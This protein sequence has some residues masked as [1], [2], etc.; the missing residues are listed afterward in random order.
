MSRKK[1]STVA[2]IASFIAVLLGIALFVYRAAFLKG[3][4][5]DFPDITVIPK[6]AEASLQAQAKRA[7]SFRPTDAEA[8]LITRLED[9]HLA[10]TGQETEVPSASVERQVDAFRQSLKSAA[11]TDHARVLL[12]G[13]YLADRFQKALEAFLAESP[14]AGKNQAG[15]MMRLIMTGGAFYMKAVQRKLIN[16]DHT[17]NVSKALPAVLFRYRWRILAG[18]PGD[19]GFTDTEQKLLFDFTIRYVD[20]QEVD[21]RLSAVKRLSALVPGYDS[22]IAEALVLYE[23]DRYKEAIRVLDGAVAR[24]RQDATV[25]NF[26]RAIERAL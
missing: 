23:A 7:R 15:E 21:R 18:L 10:E 3:H 13:D 11:K 6:D 16:P 1:T 26:R 14:A 20:K 19:D 25:E 4:I 17:L 12:L 5:P 8:E 24:G 9:I 22:D 2:L